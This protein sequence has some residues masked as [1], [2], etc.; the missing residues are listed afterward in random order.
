MLSVKRIVKGIPKGS[1]FHD[2][3]VREAHLLK[4]LNSP[5]IPVIYDVEE[6][7]RFTYI[8]EQY[9]EGESLGAVF[10]KRLLSER[11]LFL[12]IIRISSIIK[13]LHT[14][15][16]KIYYLDMKPGNIIICGEEVYLVDF[17]SAAQESSSAGDLR[18]GTKGYCAPELEDGRAIDEKADIYSLGVLLRSMTEHSDISKNTEKKLLRIADKACSRSV[19][20]RISKAD[21]FIKMLEKIRDGET[22]NTKK[23]RKI[24]EK[25]RGKRIGIMGLSQGNG[26]TTMTLAMAEYLRHAGLKKICVVEQND[27]E[28]IDGFIRCRGG[29]RDEVTKAWVKGGIYYLTGI[30]GQQRLKALN[31]S[32]DCMI[33]DLGPDVGNALGTM[34][35]CDIRI[36]AA[37]AAPWRRKEYSI[38]EKLG[39]NRKDLKNWIIFV[40]LADNKSL[41]DFGNYGAGMLPFPYEPDPLN[42]GAETIRLFEKA[43]RMIP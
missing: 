6:D 29:R 38:F 20:N 15:P 1:P 9:I 40:N 30:P 35:L 36:V 12:Y 37:G 14:L 28:D 23:G 43:F 33:F 27:R 25:L 3:L 42:P 19:W 21:I 31:D 24:S 22:C 32:Y 39:G 34:W 18:S 16:E 2:R 41:A 13:Y 11:E 17:G 10:Q 5:N 26:V 8:I 4:N 7:D